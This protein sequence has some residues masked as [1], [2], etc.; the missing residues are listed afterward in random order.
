MIVMLKVNKMVFV[1]EIKNNLLKS[2]HL[3]DRIVFGY[4]DVFAQ[5]LEQ[6]IC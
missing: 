4:T 1:G 5:L 6:L 2:A 3:L